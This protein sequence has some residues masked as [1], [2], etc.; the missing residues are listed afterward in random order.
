MWLCAQVDD[1]RCDTRR[2]GLDTGS[3][4]GEGPLVHGRP[5]NGGAVAADAARA[6]LL[7][8]RLPP[9]VHSR[10]CDGGQAELEVFQPQSLAGSVVH[11]YAPALLGLDKLAQH[12]FLTIRVRPLRQS[13]E[14]HEL[15]LAEGSAR[16]GRQSRSLEASTSSI[17]GSP[18]QQRP[19][20]RSRHQL[21]GAVRQQSSPQ[22]RAGISA[23]E[24][25]LLHARK[26]HQHARLKRVTTIHCRRHGC[27]RDRSLR[28]HLCNR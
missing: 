11:A 4:L 6:E 26:T 10:A 1:L 13:H 16:G 8:C 7:L 28:S 2:Q 5:R 14:P 20:C 9:K 23:G 19:C 15:A 21:L 12:A 25:G 22:A 24:G 17:L 3:T 27:L 18:A